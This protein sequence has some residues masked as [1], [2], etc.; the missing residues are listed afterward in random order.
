MHANDGAHPDP[1]EAGQNGGRNCE[2]ADP[3]ALL[4]VYKKLRHMSGALREIDDYFESRPA[5][6]GPAVAAPPRF[7]AGRVTLENLDAHMR[8]EGA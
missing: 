4:R 1:L 3:A 6:L 2:D 8:R 7:A 5:W